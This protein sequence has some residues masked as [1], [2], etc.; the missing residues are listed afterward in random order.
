MSLSWGPLHNILQ[1]ASPDTKILTFCTGGIRCVKV[2]AY[3]KQ[4]MGFRNIGRLKD[5]IIGY[6]RWAQNQGG[7]EYSIGVHDSCDA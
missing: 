1:N 3:L 2:N 5:G 6:E 4:K 7:E